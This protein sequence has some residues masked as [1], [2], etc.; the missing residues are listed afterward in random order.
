MKAVPKKIMCFTV[1]FTLVLAISFFPQEFNLANSKTSSSAYACTDYNKDAEFSFPNEYN[2]TPYS[3][4]TF[5]MCSGSLVNRNETHWYTPDNSEF[6][7]DSFSGY[8][9]N[10]N[11]PYIITNYN[12]VVSVGWLEYRLD[13]VP[14]Y[15]TPGNYIDIDAH[16][17]KVWGL[18][19][20]AYSALWETFTN[21]GCVQVL[22]NIVYPTW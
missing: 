12:V 18:K 19:G 10:N 9:F 13:R 7:V 3:W 11:T 22:R 5:Y 15:V 14:C 2:H 17:S 16:V 8:S 20:D 1:V 4:Y 6:V 21:D